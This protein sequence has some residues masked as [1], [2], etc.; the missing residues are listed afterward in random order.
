MHDYSID[1]TVRRY[2]HVVIALVSL[3]LPAAIRD[4]L[5][6]WGA[7]PN[8]GFVISFGATFALFYFLFETFV[9]KWL[10]FAHGIPDLNGNWT[11]R[12][13]SSYK[14]PDTGENRQ[15]SMAVKIRQ[16]FSRMEVFTDT[17]ESTSRS[18]MASME[19]EHSVPLF[20]Y[21]YDNT[22]KNMSNAELQ[23]HP[24]MMELRL[25]NADTLEGDYFSGKHRLRYGEL[26]M[27]R[28]AQ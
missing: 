23:R 27:T 28:D 16:T 2:A 12:G 13:T 4:I 10:T 1:T 9:W 26:V 18:F 22:P 8:W 11:A 15:F 5:A 25:T 17:A 7:P 24:G 21:G 3:S 20:R 14:D 19:V 6:T